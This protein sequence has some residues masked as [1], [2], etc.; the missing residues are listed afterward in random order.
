MTAIAHM[1]NGLQA[2]ILTDGAKMVRTPTYYVFQMYKPCQDATN[3][4]LKL[5]SPWYNKDEWTMPSVSGSAVR[6]NSGQVHVGLSN[7]DPNRPVTVTAKLAEL[8]QAAVS[9]WTITAPAM[10]AINTFD[11]PDTVV[12]QAFSGARIDGDTL[13]VSLPPK[14]V[15]ML[16]LK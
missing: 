12:P 9:G 4:P 2:M 1:V 3:L 11:R 10:N 6:D 8:S 7:L 13:T 5:K 16:E 15:A 14:S